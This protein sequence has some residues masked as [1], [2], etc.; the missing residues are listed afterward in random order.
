MRTLAEFI[1]ARDHE[2]PNGEKQAGIA[3]SGANT[4]KDNGVVKQKFM[5]AEKKKRGKKMKSF[6]EWMALQEG[7]K[8]KASQEM[9]DFIKGKTNKVTLPNKPA[10]IGHQPHITGSGAHYSGPKRQK[11]RQGQ[12]QAWQK[13]QGH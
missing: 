9:S 3:S 6:K 7:K 2:D 4:V 5:G 10:A 8:K 11:T 1:Q 13:D 12:K